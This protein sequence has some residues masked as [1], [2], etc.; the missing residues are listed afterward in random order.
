MGFF[1]RQPK[2]PEQPI[3]P[4]NI[5]S[6]MERFG[7]YEFDPQLSG[8]SHEEH[9][10]QCAILSPFA[11]TDPRRFMEDLATAVL[12]TKGWAVYGASRMIWEL[13]SPGSDV[14]IRENPVYIA[15]MDAAVTF[16]RTIPG[17]QGHLRNYEWDYWWNHGGRFE[18]W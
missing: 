7:R 13:L 14:Q 4:G 9:W 10:R 1:R 3:L 11:S 6:M 5:V 8:E 12:P 18:S 17:S 16:L 15:I 2:Q